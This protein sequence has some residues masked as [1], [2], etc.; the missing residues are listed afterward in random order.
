[1]GLSRPRGP[2]SPLAPLG[3]TREGPGWMFSNISFNTLASCDYSRKKTRL[4][5]EQNT[6]SVPFS[7]YSPRIGGRG[8]LA[9]VRSSFTS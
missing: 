8:S 7:V 2:R 4:K 9:I 3:V 5:V 1:M 6:A